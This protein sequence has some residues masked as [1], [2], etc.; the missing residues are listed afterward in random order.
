MMLSVE[1]EEGEEAQPD[2]RARLGYAA[3]QRSG[4]M[5]A[6]FGVTIG[7]PSKVAPNVARDPPRPG[8]GVHV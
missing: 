3:V 1:L 5:G 7:T 8:G 2:P 4:A 6:D